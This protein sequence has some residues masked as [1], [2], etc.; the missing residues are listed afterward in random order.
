[1]KEEALLLNDI[2]DD[3]TNPNLC[4]EIILGVFCYKTKIA[5]VS[6]NK[7]VNSCL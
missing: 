5:R 2:S 3:C 4:G 1:M 7:I 6:T